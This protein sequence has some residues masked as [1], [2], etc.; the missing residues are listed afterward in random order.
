MRNALITA[1]V[2]VY[3][4]TM[5][6][7]FA[8]ENS[9]PTTSVAPSNMVQVK[10]RKPLAKVT[11]SVKQTSL[12]LLDW[13]IQVGSDRGILKNHWKQRKVSLATVLQREM[14]DIFCVQEALKEQIDFIL[15][16]C[17]GYSYVGVGRDD[18][19]E[20]GEYCAILYRSRLELL[21]HGTFWLSDTPGSPEK[22]WDAIF[23]RICTW[24]RFRDLPTGNKFCVF[25]THF[26]LLPEARDKAVKLLLNRMITE[27]TRGNMILVGDLNCEPGSGPWKAIQK[28]GLT[29]AEYL[30]AKNTKRTKTYHLYGM[31]TN[32][33]DAVFLPSNVRV[34]KHRVVTDIVGK[35]YPSDHFGTH[36]AFEFAQRRK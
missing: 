5:S 15:T 25:N 4:I 11:P 13:N 7:V 18:G 26:P 10:A 3:T 23:K 19:K 34:L 30:F 20:A 17:P 36:V 2:S 35:Y 12:T 1:L 29:D 28:F 14:P 32:V 24:A 31:P 9:K 33:Y 16:K 21:D 8:A 22:T 6:S 27:C